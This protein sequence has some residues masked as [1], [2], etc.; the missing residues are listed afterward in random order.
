VPVAAVLLVPANGAW[1]AP[2]YKVLH[3]FTGGLDGGGL[4]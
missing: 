1:A 4:T 3:N 2:K